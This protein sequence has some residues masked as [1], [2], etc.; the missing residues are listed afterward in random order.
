MSEL[1]ACIGIS[2]ALLCASIVGC[3]FGLFD[4]ISELTHEI[5]ELRMDLEQGIEIDGK[6]QNDETNR[7]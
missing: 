1:V 4:K 2:V 6:E 3:S 7:C 5:W